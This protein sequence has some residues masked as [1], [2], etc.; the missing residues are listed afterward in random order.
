VAAAWQG[1]PYSP[2]EIVANDKKYVHSVRYWKDLDEA[3]IRG[4][5]RKQRSNRPA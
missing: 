5:F 1:L 3:A 4:F 2:Q